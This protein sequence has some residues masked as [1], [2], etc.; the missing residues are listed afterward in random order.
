MRRGQEMATISELASTIAQA[1]GLDLATVALIARYVREA[2]FIKKKGRGPS[3]A[4]MVVAD[5]ANLLI[6][7]NASTAAIEAGEVVPVYR[8]LAA[9]ESDNKG[10]R[11]K[12]NGT[13]GEALELLIEAAIE[14]KLPESFLSAVVDASVR[15][16]FEQGKAELSIEF[17]KPDPKASITI[18]RSVT[19]V[20]NPSL[21]YAIMPKHIFRLD[22]VAMRAR[23]D[24]RQRR[25]GDRKDHTEIGHLTIF[26]IA[27]V[28]QPRSGRK[29]SIVT[30]EG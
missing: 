22:F 1:E 9:F 2:G 13:F 23:S 8:E 17:E 5:A 27:K 24:Q 11:S 29:H 7:V 10:R 6:A 18:S 14:R 20:S 12:R 16:A 19:K 25:T 21:G 3:A 26:S 4:R 28:L 15:D 30:S